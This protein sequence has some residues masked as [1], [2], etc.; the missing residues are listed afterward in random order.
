MFW[1]LSSKEQRILKRKV[2]N[3]KLIQ[4]QPSRTFKYEQTIFLA[5]D[6][7]KKIYKKLE[8]DIGTGLLIKETTSLRDLNNKEER[9]QKAV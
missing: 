8:S 5:G 6:S 1:N 9:F 4:K 7:S 2:L 3:N